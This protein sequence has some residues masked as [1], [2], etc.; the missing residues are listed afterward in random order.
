M[1]FSEGDTEREVVPG[2]DVLNSNFVLQ[3]YNDLDDWR[4]DFGGHASDRKGNKFCE[5]KPAARKA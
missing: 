3:G 1:I 4:E 2:R 5:A